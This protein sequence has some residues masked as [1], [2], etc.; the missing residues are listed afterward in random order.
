MRI[1][2]PVG[3]RPEVIKLAGVVTALRAAGHDVRCVATGQHSDPA[4]AGDIFTALGCRPDATWSLPAAESERVGGLLSAAFAEFATHRPDVVL[5]LGDTYTAPLVAMAARRF[6]VGVAH[7]EAGLRSFNQLSME[8]TN[9]RLMVA[10]ATLHLAPTDLAARFLATE[11]VPAERIRVVGNTVVDALRASG[12]ARV[13]LAERAG[14]AVTAHRATNVDDPERLAELVRLVRTLGDRLGPVTFPLHPRTRDRLT[15][16]GRLDDLVGA[17]GVT[18]TDPLPYD[19]MLRLLARSRLV[20]T[21]SG[22][23]QEEASYF[24]VPAIVLRRSTPRW[25]GVETGA[26]A[27]AGLDTERV[28]ELAERFTAPAEL[29]RIAALPCPYGDGHAVDRVVEALADPDLV[30][31]LRPVEPDFTAEAA[32]LPEIVDGALAPSLAGGRVA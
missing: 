24:G 13:A 21:D 6:G 22:G 23:L 28:L 3:T 12:V 31:I 11:G 20:V 2:V 18:L 10:L 16:A 15:K 14:V 5:V 7:L 32:T 8:E 9:R 1:T 30:R 19:G 4:L 17:P 25:E 26:A 29:T 27:L